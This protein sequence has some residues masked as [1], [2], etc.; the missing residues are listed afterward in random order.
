V[1]VL[2]G[3]CARDDEAAMRARL[4]AWFGLGETLAFYARSDCAVAVFRLS[5]GGIGASVPVGTSVPEMLRAL[6]GRAAAAVDDPD[7]AP[8]AAMVEIANAER[9][10]GMAMRRASLEARA[11]MDDRVESAFRRVLLNPRAILAYDP[12][13]RAVMLLD[14]E[15]GLLFVAMGAKA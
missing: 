12:R 2:T 1:V 10:T 4:S 8:D 13:E 7:L 6:P 5:H 11:C 14:R 3:A 15:S 9:P